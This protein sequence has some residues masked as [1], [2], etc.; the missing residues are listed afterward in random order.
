[1]SRRKRETP[2]SAA[3]ERLIEEIT[4]DAYGEAEQR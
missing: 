1:M 3:A 4:I 2:E